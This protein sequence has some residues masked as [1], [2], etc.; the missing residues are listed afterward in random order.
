MKKAI[1]L[2]LDGVGV[3]GAP[4]AAQYND[5]GSNTLGNLAKRV[6]GLSLPNLEKL[7]LGNIIEIDGVPKSNEPQAAF[8]KCIERSEGKDSTTGHWEIA[9]LISRKPFPTYPNGFPQ[10]IMD[11]F[12]DDIDVDL[13]LG[14]KVASGT[15]IIDEL[16]E[17]HMETGF[18]IVYT[19]A[20]SVFQIAAHV[21]IIPLEMLYEW[22][23]AARRILTGN[24]AVSRVIARPFE[25]KPGNFTRTVDRKDYSLVPHG[26]TILDITKKAGLP[27]TGIGKIED[28]FA[29]RGLT[30]SY[31]THIN[32][33]GIVKT[34]E[35]LSKQESGLVFINLVDTDQLYGH[36]N[37]CEGFYGSLREFD[38][39][40]PDILAA[41]SS[42]DILI[43][44][45]DHGNDPTTPSTDHSR[46]MVPILVYGKSILPKDLGIRKSFA[47]IGQS[48]AD[49]LDIPKTPDGT[50]FL[51][52]ILKG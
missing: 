10:E 7:G 27:V 3:G 8:G 51:S 49:F 25:G 35:I 23:E 24:H 30:E 6:G 20:D 39:A 46:E 14:N 33:E 38:L 17:E 43:I 2:I 16:G 41:L 50:S 31:H 34:I 1:I 47:D 28:L 42:E 19:S 52:E 5:E 44:T 21:D 29:H 36:R 12:L 45:A 40:L 11:E 48:I 15:V 32:S 13:A 22:C 37:N 26:P 18:P 4:D 9:G